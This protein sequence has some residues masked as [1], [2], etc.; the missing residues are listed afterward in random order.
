VSQRRLKTDIQSD[1]WGRASILVGD[2]TGHCE[3][4]FDRKCQILNGYGDRAVWIPRF[5]FW[6]LGEEWRL[7]KKG[8]YTRRI[9]RSL[10][11]IL[12]AI[13]SIKTREDQFRR[14]THDLRTWVAKYTEVD[15]GI[16]EHLLWTLT[17]LLIRLE[18]K[19]KTQ[20]TVNNFSFSFIIH[21][22]L[23]S[24]D[25]NSSISV[26]IHNQ[27]HVLMIF[28]SQWPT[29]SPPKIFYFYLNHFLYRIQ[30]CSVDTVQVMR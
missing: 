5:L 1:S 24:V 30:V 23:V 13:A 12:D 2:R 6:G 16:F 7:Q 18:I 14:T 4:K 11:R 20:L 15:G 9:A 3:E 19:I 21:N 28:F 22:P 26:I 17:N 10:A 25:S 27:K 29:L 8:G